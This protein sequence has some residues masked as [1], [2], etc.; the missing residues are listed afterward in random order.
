MIFA[1]SADRHTSTRVRSRRPSDELTLIEP[2]SLAATSMGGRLVVH[3]EAQ[4]RAEEARRDC[5]RVIARIDRWAARLTRYTDSSDLVV[6]NS[7]PGSAVPVRPILAAAFRAGIAAAD[8]SEGFADITLLDARLAAEGKPDVAAASRRGEWEIVRGPRGAAVVRRPP[9]LR[10][11]F[12][13]VGKG[14][15]ADRALDLLAAWPGALIDADG[16]LAVRCAPGKFWEVGIDDPRA[17]E[18]SIAVLRLGTPYG[19]VPTRWGVATSGTSIHRWNVGGA[20]SHHLIDPRTGRPAV[21]DVVQA[22]VVAGSALRAESLAKAAIIAGSVDGFALLERARVRGAV[23]VTSNGEV[24][25]LPVTMSL[26][27]N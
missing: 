22:T 3:V 16:D 23:L 15:I 8:A 27:G 2:V 18:S 14:W 21:T 1:P 11:D 10:F 24:R 7:D 26:L 9:G 12:G 20:A 17:P 6:L 5:R 4:G 13:G 25:A 19:G